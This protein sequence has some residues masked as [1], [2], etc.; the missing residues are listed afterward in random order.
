MVFLKKFIWRLI[1]MYNR[2]YI[3]KNI[4]G[5]ENLFYHGFKDGNFVK[6][7]IC[8][9]VQLMIEDL[10]Y[11]YV[12]FNVHYHENFGKEINFKIKKEIDYYV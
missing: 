9:D 7:N 6:N 11:D 2:K 5:D 4:L 10:L 1:I 3:K 8:L 12:F